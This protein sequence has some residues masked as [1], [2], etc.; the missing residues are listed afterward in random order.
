MTK[1]KT[2]NQGT[3]YW[4][5]TCILYRIKNSI[6]SFCFNF[7]HESCLLYF[8]RNIFMWPKKVNLG[9]Y[10]FLFVSLFFSSASYAVIKVGDQVFYDS[11]NE[12]K[13]S[14][15][16]VLARDSKDTFIVGQLGHIT[17]A[18]VSSSKL[19]E[20]ISVDSK[21]Q[22]KKGDLFRGNVLPTHHGFG[23][24]WT[25]FDAVVTDVFEGGWLST[26]DELGRVGFIRTK[27]TIPCLDKYA[28]LTQGQT[29]HHVFGGEGTI[30]CL[31][32]DNTAYIDF[33]NKGV[34][35]THVK[36]NEL[37]AG[38]KLLLPEVV[39]VSK[40]VG[41]SVDASRTEKTVL[42]DEHQNSAINDLSST[43]KMAPLSP[44]GLR[45]QSPT[46]HRESSKTSNLIMP[47]DSIVGNSVIAHKH[48]SIAVPTS[49]T[50]QAAPV[51]S[52]P[53][54]VKSQTPMKPSAASVVTSAALPQRQWVQAPSSIQVNVLVGDPTSTKQSSALAQLLANIAEYN[55]LVH[56]E[57]NSMVGEN[58]GQSLIVAK[59]SSQ[60]D[61]GDVAL[62][63]EAEL[64]GLASVVSTSSSSK[65][66]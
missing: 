37:T 22:F 15:V 20:K 23:S 42:S 53:T 49:S 65:A 16:T 57:H 63:G 61:K 33:K 50:A 26:I 59:A 11:K 6:N 43:S 1:L 10:S 38:S 34:V 8:M 21:T 40:P 24:K 13:R 19:R 51:Q 44:T 45:L 9:I 31:Y 25:A 36:L 17:G 3:I 52:Q 30:K 39:S 46:V 18:V 2:Y 28:G 5:S 54:K 60:V 35:T 56:S 62:P 29:V 64:S 48:T 12:Y 32:S 14:L 4:A 66:N 7:W 47:E 58:L 41:L 27:K 55:R